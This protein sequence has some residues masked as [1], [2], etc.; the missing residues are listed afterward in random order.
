MFLDDDAH[1]VP[2][3]E[4]QALLASAS[5]GR[6]SLT[7]RALPVVMPVNYGYLGGNIILSMSDGPAQRAI[8]GGNIIALGVDNANL[9][10]PFW[11]VLVIGR[12]N[13]ITDE[14][15]C[16]EYRRLGLTAQ[17]DGA[18]GESHYLQL[19]PDILTGHRANCVVAR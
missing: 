9:P 7:L 1:N 3:N 8:S 18:A 14:A 10:E 19:R 4:C 6:L 5:I 2:S 13:E 16:V 17:T 11:A 15:A 12:A